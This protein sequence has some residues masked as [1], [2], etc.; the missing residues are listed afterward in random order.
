M[1]VMVNVVGTLVLA[2]LMVS[3][4]RS[5][6]A[7]NSGKAVGRNGMSPP[8]I[9]IVGSAVQFFAKYEQ[10]LEAS[11]SGEGILRWFSDKERWNGKITQDRY[12]LSK[13]M[14]QM[15]VRCLAKQVSKGEK[16]GKGM[17]V[18]NCLNPGYCR[19]ER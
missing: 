11:Q 15:L 16:E 10:L 19:T 4:M 2:V 17:V 13:G 14:V 9:S 1:T 8:R 3:V 18:V 7:R 5:Q 6:M 12:N